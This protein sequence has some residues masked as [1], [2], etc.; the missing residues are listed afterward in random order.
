MEALILITSTTSGNDATTP[1]QA[2]EET[3][4][5]FIRTLVNVNASHVQISL[6]H[7]ISVVTLGNVAVV[8]SAHVFEL[9]CYSY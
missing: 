6:G 5:E 4:T 1:A 3:G 7:K 9:I 2:K 8:M